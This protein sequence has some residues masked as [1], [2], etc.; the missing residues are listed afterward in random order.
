MGKKFALKRARTS[1]AGAVVGMLI[2]AGM[3]A[4]GSLFVVSVVL[5]AVAT[6]IF[7]RLEPSF[8]KVL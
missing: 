8:A 4:L 3:V 6:I 7:K 5:I 1:A 2:V